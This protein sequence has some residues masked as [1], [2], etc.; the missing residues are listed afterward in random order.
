MITEPTNNQ[1]SGVKASTASSEARNRYGTPHEGVQGRRRTDHDD[2][3]R[4][5]R[6]VWK[7]SDSVPTGRRVHPI[8]SDVKRE[9]ARIGPNRF[10][11]FP[12]QLKLSPLENG[13]DSFHA[14]MIV[15]GPRY[16]E[17]YEPHGN[18]HLNVNVALYDKLREFLV[19]FALNTG[20]TLVDVSDSCPYG[21]QYIALDEGLCVAWSYMFLEARL[22]NPTMP[23]AELA[24]ALRKDVIFEGNMTRKFPNDLRTRG[25][26]VT[27]SH[28]RCRVGGRQTVC[29][30][31]HVKI[32]RRRKPQETPTLIFTCPSPT[33]T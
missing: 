15:I 9:I 14:N 18:N 10:A 28:V 1:K 33:R 13:S 8:L 32:W 7:Y 2:R 11:A 24:F 22:N 31:A 6:H 16:V 27:G 5:H 20:R 12:L 30:H 17:W 19:A 29:V 3:F 25:R 21:L 26:G 4:T 23:T